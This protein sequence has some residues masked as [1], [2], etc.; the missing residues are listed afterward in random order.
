MV[1]G[2]GIGGLRYAGN[3][4][5][6]TPL[7]APGFGRTR[8][9][10][11]SSDCDLGHATPVTAVA[12]LQR[13]CNDAGIQG[14]ARHGGMRDMKLY[15][16]NALPPGSGVRQVFD[17]IVHTG[18]VG[19]RGGAP[20]SINDGSEA[21]RQEFVAKAPAEANAVIGVQVA[22]D[23]ALYDIG[24]GGAF[25]LTYCGNPAVIGDA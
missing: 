13:F 16:G 17:M 23:V 21:V 12:P 2:S 10:L 9:P 8:L 24:G 6:P 20:G 15:S 18:T 25:Y 7:G 22:T 3:G 14:V 19:F 11:H 5:G 1:S 4:A